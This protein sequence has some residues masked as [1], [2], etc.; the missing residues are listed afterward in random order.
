MNF[1]NDELT[2]LM[3]HDQEN[4]WPYCPRCGKMLKIDPL[5]ER[6]SFSNALS[7]E[8]SDLYVCDACGMD[9]AYRAFEGRPLP[10]EQWQ[11]TRLIHIM[12]K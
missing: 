12:Y 8:V 4:G 1:T 6:A 5:T 7:R 11:H 3:I 2:R 10:L 9:E